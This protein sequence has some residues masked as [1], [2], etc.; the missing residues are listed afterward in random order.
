MV[1]HFQVA[2]VCCTQAGPFDNLLLHG[3]LAVDLFFVLSG[4]TLAMVYS[5]A[6][7]GA[8]N[9][10]TYADFLMRRFARVWPLLAVAVCAGLAVAL[11][12]HE[13]M[14]H[15]VWTTS[16]DLMMLDGWELAASLG[17][18]TW[19]ISTEWAAY[20]LFPLLLLVTVR[21]RRRTAVLFG[22]L[23]FLPLVWL[24]A[25]FGQVTPWR[26]GILDIYVAQGPLP[27]LRCLAGFTLGLLAYRASQDE[28]VMRL[29]GYRLVGAGVVAA[30]LVL[31]CLPRTDLLIELLFP[32][33][34]LVAMAEATP[35]ARLLGS[36][37]PYILGVWSYSIYLAHTHFIGAEMQL[38]G[39]L[40]VRVGPF[41]HVLAL[42]FFYAVIIGVAALLFH[43]VESQGR[44]ILTSFAWMRRRRPAPEP[45]RV[46]E[47]AETVPA[48]PGL[49]GEQTGLG[50]PTSMG[51]A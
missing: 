33:L 31:L 13:P 28:R 18:P 30:T 15:P 16:A 24:A 9:W 10:R 22:L 50:L 7:L 49:L 5:Q 36:P 37:L 12:K 48:N 39:W 44:R 26:H 29:A 40:V 43:T 14:P 3:Y 6:M 32:L 4:Y 20:L 2:S 23:S 46:E 25:T 41:G 42:A 34:V 51:P 19:S 45:R 47:L 21:A 38:S 17:G 27:L 1:Y 35:I 11:M 8:F